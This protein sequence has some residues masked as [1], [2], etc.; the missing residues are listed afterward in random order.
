V[1]A[2]RP[3]ACTTAVPGLGQRGGDVDPHRQCPAQPLRGSCC[4]VSRRRGRRACAT[5][6]DSVPE[7][8]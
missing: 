2:G 8:V 1:E 5:A 6:A 3:G 4:D 7:A